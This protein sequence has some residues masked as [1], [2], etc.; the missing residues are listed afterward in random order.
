MRINPRL[1]DSLH[2]S[3]KEAISSAESTETVDL[4]TLSNDDLRHKSII[5]ADAMRRLEAKYYAAGH[6]RIYIQYS[7]PEERD[8]QHN[9]E[10]IAR[11][12]AR[13]DCRTEYTIT[14]R[15]KAV[16]YCNEMLRREDKPPITNWWATGVDYSNVPHALTDGMLSGVSPILEAAD[17]LENMARK[18]P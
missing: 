14:Y 6:P 17:F 15:P 11:D 13:E 18:L 3:R 8:R 5:H 7:T 16:A 12:R 2:L 9:N 10:Q 1:L 4:R